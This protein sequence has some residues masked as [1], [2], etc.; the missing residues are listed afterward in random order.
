MKNKQLNKAKIVKND[1]FYT[2]FS[3]IENELN[4]YDFT[5]KIV[6]SNCDNENSNFVKFF[7]EN[8]E[9][10]KY[11]DY[12]Y[13]YYDKNTDKGSFDSKESLE[14][15]NKCDIVVTNP[16]FSKIKEFIDLLVESDKDFIIIGN[17]G[18]VSYKNVFYYIMNNQINIGYTYPK[19]FITENNSIKKFGNVCWFTNLPV[20]NS[21]KLNLSKQYSSDIHRFY[22]NYKCINVDRIKDIPNDYFEVMGVPLTILTYDYK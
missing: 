12:F 11:K 13:S 10:L 9:K 15:L 21:R 22:D 20:N 6:Y 1:E 2:L 3:D 8:K 16:P 18:N 19:Q 14:L 7:K 4:Y 5:D 17:Q